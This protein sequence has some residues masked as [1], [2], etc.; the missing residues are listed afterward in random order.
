ME[1]RNRDTVE[2]YDDQYMIAQVS[3]SIVPPVG[4][5]INIQKRTWVVTAV[6]YALDHAD[7]QTERSMRANVDL[8]CDAA[9]KEQQ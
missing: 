7:S 5:R 4:A 3:S 2:F 1:I 8:V 9:I 6:T